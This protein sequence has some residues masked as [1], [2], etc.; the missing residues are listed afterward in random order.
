MQPVGVVAKRSGRELV[1]A[2]P[3]SIGG[4]CGEG[5]PALPGAA[6]SP[7]AGDSD[8]KA[9]PRPESDPQW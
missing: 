8:L 4:N 6:G 3:R 9:R 2:P 7:A 1:Q 5:L